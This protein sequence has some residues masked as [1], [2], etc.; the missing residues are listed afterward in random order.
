MKRHLI[1]VAVTLVMIVLACGSMDSQSASN[2]GIS[3]ANSSSSA[4]TADAPSTKENGEGSASGAAGLSSPSEPLIHKMKETV[5][6]GYTSYEV[7]STRW[8]TQLSNNQFLNQRPDATYLIIE[9][10]V[11]NNDTKPRTIPP[12]KLLDKNNAEYETSS[13]ALMVEGNIGPLDS[14]NPG[15]TKQGLIV[16]D[17]PEKHSYRLIVSGG[18]WSGETALIELVDREKEAQ[19][20]LKIQEW[21]KNDKEYQKKKQAMAASTSTLE[22]KTNAAAGTDNAESPESKAAR[23]NSNEEAF[24]TWKAQGSKDTQPKTTEEQANAHSEFR[25]WTSTSGNHSIEATIRSLANGV[26]TLEKPDGTKISVPQDKL[27]EA[28]RDYITTWRREKQHQH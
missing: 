25:T 17:V 6:V 24:K 18:F 28:D 26:V 2:R 13:N 5:N 14:L 22:T 3:V 27:G 1:S 21:K 15:V 20:D 7:W 19:R 11:R 23:V 8:S 12:F 16:F 4:T 9:V 10:S